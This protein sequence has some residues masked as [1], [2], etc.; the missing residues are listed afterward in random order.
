M[1]EKRIKTGAQR[2]QLNLPSLF[3]IHLNQALLSTAPLKLLSWK[4]PVTFMLPNSVML[5]ILVS[6][7]SSSSTCHHSTD[8]TPSSWE[9]IRTT[10]YSFGSP[11]PLL[12]LLFSTLI[13]APG[14]SPWP[15]FFYLA[16]SFGDLIQL[17]GFPIP[18]NAVDSQIHISD[19]DLLPELQSDTACHSN[20]LCLKRRS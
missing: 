9:Y 13:L 10:P 7:V 11:S 16:H 14:H 1:I 3:P 4:S 17:H 20:L 18:S 8:E 19:I 12:W 2:N 6:S 5:V 15:S